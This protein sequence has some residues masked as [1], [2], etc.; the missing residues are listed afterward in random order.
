MAGWSG[1]TTKVP[2]FE[3]SSLTLLLVV[4]RG[5]ADV[6]GVGDK[7]G[8]GSSNLPPETSMIG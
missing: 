3:L 5:E 6:L 7:P 1:L 8:Y 2:T 4:E